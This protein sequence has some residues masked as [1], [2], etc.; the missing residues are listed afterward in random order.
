MSLNENHAFFSMADAL[1][2]YTD[3]LRFVTSQNPIQLSMNGKIYSIHTS[4]IHDSGNSRENENEQR[5]Q[6]S[7]KT[8]KLQIDREK[9]GSEV[10]FIGFFP[11]GTGFT[12]WEPAYVLSQRNVG[13]GSIYA[14]E[15]HRNLI[16]TK[17]FAIRNFQSRNLQRPT[18]TLALPSNLLGFYVENW[19]NLHK[20]GSE[21]DIRR[22]IDI[23]SEVP[24]SRGAHPEVATKFLKIGGVRKKITVTRTF[25]AR[26][27]L[28][29][30]SILK[31]YQNSC[32]ICGRQMGIVQAAHII[33]HGHPDSRDHVQNGLALCIEHHKLYD[34]GLIL[35]TSNQR[36]LINPDRME[37]LRFIKQSSGLNQLNALSSKKFNIPEDEIHQPDNELLERGVRIRT[38]LG[39]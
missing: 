23:A 35:P 14:R 26:N 2:P 18:S 27:P 8:I 9:S 13:R 29:T 1:R 12:A 5:I 16:M 21:I 36:I 22:A 34:D 7:Q 25:Y 32:C 4:I 11:D 19:R 28:F 30:K 17:G 3:D 15:S 20:A 38:G 10:L 6:I 37:Y 24:A 31:V 33:P 39:D